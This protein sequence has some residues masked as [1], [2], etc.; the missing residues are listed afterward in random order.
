M[1]AGEVEIIDLSLGGISIKAEKRLN[2]GDEHALKIQDKEKA[3]SLR[4]T[5]VWSLLSGTRKNPKGEAIPVY[6]AGMKFTAATDNETAELD[7]LIERHRHEIDTQKAI[8]GLR[9]LR[10]KIRFPVNIGGDVNLYIF[11]N[12]RVKKLSLGGMLFESERTLKIEHECPMEILLP[13]GNLIGFLGR[14]A[15]C[16][17]IHHESKEYYDIGVEFLDMPKKD[18]ERLGKFL[19]T[20]Q[21]EAKPSS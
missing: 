7:K 19:S 20:L 11:E 18:R 4:G 16:L 8:P 17:P 2:I 13:G 5:V 12:Y 9:E 14:I 6:T 21:K 10:C 15:S 1:S 3:L